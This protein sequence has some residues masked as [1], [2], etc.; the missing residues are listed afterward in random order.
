MQLI[1][2]YLAVM[3]SAP[4]LLSIVVILIVSKF[5]D[6]I[7]GLLSRV[8]TI[9]LPGGTEVDTQRMRGI[10]ED[11]TTTPP[12]TDDTPVNI[13]TELPPPQRHEVES[14]VRSHIAEARLWEYRFLNYFL[15]RRTQSILDWLLDLPEPITVTHYESL[16]QPIIPAHERSAIVA[17]LETH[18]LI[19][20]DRVTST[21]SV[22]PK[23]REYHEWRGPL[24]FAKHGS[25]PTPYVDLMDTADR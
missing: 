6:D 10:G 2:D 12:N 17:A 19:Q 18:R 15:V 1:L 8:A 7:R 11:K 14:L 16:F 4:P 24:P 23:G 9:R 22:T 3:L 5:S 25:P 13:P 20:I 21:I